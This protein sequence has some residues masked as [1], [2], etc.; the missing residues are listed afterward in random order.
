MSWLIYILT[1]GHC[2]GK[3]RKCL[4]HLF[5]YHFS[6]GELPK[7]VGS[8]LLMFDPFV[9]ISFFKRR[10]IKYDGLWLIMSHQLDNLSYASKY[11]NS[12]IPLCLLFLSQA[13]PYL[14]FSLFCILFILFYFLIIIFKIWIIIIKINNISKNDINK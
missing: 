9:H 6:K 4:T 2:R 13:Y 7:M 11:K 3:T 14:A 12:N 1:C 5:I 10:I 8:I